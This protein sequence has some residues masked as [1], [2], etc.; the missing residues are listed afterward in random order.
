MISTVNKYL[1]LVKFSHTIFAMPFALTGFFMAVTRG[2]GSFSWL[3]FGLVVLCMVFARS[4][5]MAFNR[6]LDVDI[7]KLN[8]RTAKREIPAGV[9]SA[10]NA[11]YFIIANCLLFIATT[12][13]INRICFFLSPVALAVVLGYSY[14]K[15]FTALCHLVLGVG[16]SLAPI[17]AYLAVTGVFAVL[18]VLVSCL[19]LC[20][21][22][23]F[24]IIYSLQDEDF[25]RAQRLNS[26]PA[27]L[28]LAGALRF[29]ELLH[30]IAAAL[31][32]TIGLAGHFHWVYWIGSAVFVAMLVSQ[33][34]LVKPDDLSKI[35]IMFMTTNGIASVVYA[36]FAIADMLI[37]A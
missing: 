10:R 33:H 13:F 28:G 16:L 8:P 17:G 35:N 23:G 6:W 18:P 4:A 20:W 34:L 14:T 31:V 29:S 32:I 9:I 25:D 22:S 24:D 15:R 19:V 12:W 36:V 27:W 5:A 7:D 21:V 30:V 3:T 2:E 26:I 37:F 11:G 1:S